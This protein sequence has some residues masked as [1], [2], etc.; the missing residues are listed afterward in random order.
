MT[1]ND[2]PL[3]TERQA[4]VMRILW[5]EGSATVREAK[6]QMA[7]DLA[8]T[9]VLAIFQ[10]LYERGHVRY[11]HE[12]KAYRYFPLTSREDAAEQFADHLWTLD[13]DMAMETARELRTLY[14]QEVA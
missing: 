8:Y 7:D 10:T 2:K 9:S 13:G 11:E 14:E 3:I 1:T 12:G 5:N 4:D 6:E